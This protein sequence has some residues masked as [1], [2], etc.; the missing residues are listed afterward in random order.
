M[1]LG[2]GKRRRP[3][4][5]ADANGRSDH[6]AQFRHDEDR[7]FQPG[8]QP[9]AQR[10]GR[11]RR[12]EAG[13]EPLRGAFG[14]VD[15]LALHAAPGIPR[16]VDRVDRA[17]RA[18]AGVFG[19]HMAEQEPAPC[20]RTTGVRGCLARGAVA[21]LFGLEHLAERFGERVSAPVRAAGD[22]PGPRA[23]IEA[24]LMAALPTDDESRTFQPG[25]PPEPP[26][27]Q[28]TGPLP[29]WISRS[30]R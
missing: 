18:E 10:L 7:L 1:K 19:Y 21:L 30:D 2:Q 22:S 11:E 4:Y 5:A 23:V 14:L 17:V 3:A 28:M 12:E 27:P 15:R 16:G 25:P 29:K 8:R 26:L 20:T 24:L 6:R 13:E 9:R